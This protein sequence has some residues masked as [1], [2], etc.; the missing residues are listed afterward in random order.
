MGFLNWSSIFYWI[1]Y[2]IKLFVIIALSAYIWWGIEANK[3]VEKELADCQ[4]KFSNLDVYVGG[5][6]RT[7]D[8]QQK[9]S[10]NIIK[11]NADLQSAIQN[12]A[13]ELVKKQKEVD[14]A[15][16]KLS[17]KPSGKTCKEN[18]KWMKKI[19]KELSW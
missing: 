5:L 6:E 17:S 16:I 3:R 8:I 9:K 12:T 15:I 10:A 2:N 11:E 1:Q 7:I 19:V 13:N 18:M 4:D 14:K